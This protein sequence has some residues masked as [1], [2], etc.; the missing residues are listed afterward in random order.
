MTISIKP[1]LA[2]LDGDIIAYRAA[3]WA[4]EEGSEWL[5]DRIKD[6]ILKWT[7]E[8]VSKIAVAFSC[9]RAD[10]FRRTW[11]PEYKEN[12]DVFRQ[13][14]ENLTYAKEIIQGNYDC[15]SYPTLEADDI[16]GLYMTKELAIG[17]TIDKDIYSVYGWSWKPTMKS[18]EEPNKILYTSKEEADYNFH[19][20]WI[21][22]DVTDN[23]PGVWKLGPAK[24]DKFLKATNPVNHS[25][26]VLSLYERFP[27]KTNNKYTFQDALAQARCVRILRKEDW[28]NS[29]V[30][31]WVPDY[32]Q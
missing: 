32:L 27:T 21:T 23:I 29:K 19:K 16:I 20:Q 1:N 30:K 4:D 5:E 12:R 18:E 26:L 8:G 11:W 24:A 2:I 15:K 13:T 25:A 14:P 9:S 7:P 6:D 28:V 31:P 3:W 17:V 10:N 22:G